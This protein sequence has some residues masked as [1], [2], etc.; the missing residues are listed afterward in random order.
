MSVASTSAGIPFEDLPVNGA[1]GLRHAWDVLD[2]D[3]G[4]LARLTPALVA[5]AAATVR[6]G[7]V[8]SLSLPVDVPDPPLFGREPIRHEIFALDR[9]NVDE[10]LD[11]YY[12]QA[13]S[14]WDGLRHVRARESGFFGGRTDDPRPGAGPLGIE[15]WARRGIVGRGVLLDVERHRRESGTP[16]DPLGG[17]ALTS[18]D[19]AATA[20][21]QGVALDEG[22]IL[23]V[24]TGWVAAYRALDRDGR[25]AMAASPRS[26]GLR[27]DED[28]ARWLWDGGCAAVCLDNPAV[29]VIPGDPAV[30]SLHRRLIPMLGFALAELLDLEGLARACAADGRW[31][32]LFVAAPMHL[33]GGVG[34]P[35]NAVAIR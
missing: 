11:A 4:T 29:E 21:A 30:G 23:C 18:D 3:L 12:P 24:R 5:A 26:A 32:F 27:A 10:R 15:R 7:D 17:E 19:L 14:Q 25:V 28:M 13:S 2:H 8:F 31:E 34:S 16:F 33:P 22:D 35:A 9:N 20:G 1:L 6:H